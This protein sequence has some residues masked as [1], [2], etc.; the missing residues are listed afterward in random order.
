MPS[1]AD[2][3][4]GDK[5]DTSDTGDEQYINEIH[6][7][8]EN[9]DESDTDDWQCRQP[10]TNQDAEEESSQHTTHKIG[11]DMATPPPA[12]QVLRD[13]LDTS[14]SEGIIISGL[15]HLQGYR[16]TSPRVAKIWSGCHIVAF[17]CSVCLAL[18]I[19]ARIL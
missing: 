3:V 10:M 5:L 15:D 7:S 14:E 9:T 18:S 6:T 11:P 2:W 8:G 13:K 16:W 12:N 17:V 1:P 4:I 19:H